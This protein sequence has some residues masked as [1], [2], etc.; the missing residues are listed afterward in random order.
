M[1]S[2]VPFFRGTWLDNQDIDHEKSRARRRPDPR[3][4]SLICRRLKGRCHD[5]STQWRLK[6]RTSTNPL[7]RTLTLRTTKRLTN[8]HNGWDERILRQLEGG[9]ELAAMDVPREISYVEVSFPFPLIT[10]NNLCRV[11][12]LQQYLTP[13]LT[14]PTSN[15][16]NRICLSL[17]VWPSW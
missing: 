1:P 15:F 8:L 5:C 10:Q 6:L 4:C 13:L 7:E 3:T 9:D 16:P 12:S 17:V 2:A 11:M 14:L